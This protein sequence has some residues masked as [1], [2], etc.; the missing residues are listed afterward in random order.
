MNVELFWSN[1]N[2]FV[3]SSFHDVVELNDGSF[4]VLGNGSFELSAAAIATIDSKGNTISQREFTNIFNSNRNILPEESGHF[5]IPSINTNNTLTSF[6]FDT[7]LKQ[8]EEVNHQLSFENS[9]I[10]SW[11][12]NSD[13]TSTYNIFTW[14]TD[15][16]ITL[17]K[18]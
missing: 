9:I 5:W 11:L 18:K 6:K 4:V 2:Q 7:N 13:G 8:I 14:R 17:I 16:E 3:I 1:E 10:R 15:K 12:R